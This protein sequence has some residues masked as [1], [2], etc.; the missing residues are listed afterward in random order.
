MLL[1]GGGIFNDQFTASFLHYCG[2][3]RTCKIGEHFHENMDNSIVSPFFCDSR[4]YCKFG[5]ESNRIA[6]AASDF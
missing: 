4:T 1:W 6:G 5:N 3:K 2:N